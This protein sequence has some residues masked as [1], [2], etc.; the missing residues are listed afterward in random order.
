[1]L[2]DR[3][4]S[5]A[6][7][8]TVQIKARKRHGAHPPPSSNGAVMCST[9]CVCVRRVVAGAAAGLRH[10]LGVPAGL[11]GHRLLGQVREGQGG[12]LGGGGGGRAL[13]QALRRARRR[14]RGNAQPLQRRPS[15]KLCRTSC[16]SMADRVIGCAL[17]ISRRR[18][19][20]S[21]ARSSSSGT[22]PSPKSRRRRCERFL[23]LVSLV[24]RCGCA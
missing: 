9:V 21:A 1:M 15:A 17:R 22:T 14:Q 19:V 4:T 7:E 11:E 16:G 5:V 12:R 23:P 18:G 8:G 10:P 6:P 24:A 3:M 13:R 2:K 20:T